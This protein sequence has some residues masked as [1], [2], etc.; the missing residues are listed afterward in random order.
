MSSIEGIAVE[1]V[2]RCPSC[3]GPGG[4]LHADVR[5]HTFGTPG[6]WSISRCAACGLAWLDPRPTVQDIGKV[7]RSYYTHQLNQQGSTLRRHVRSSPITRTLLD[8]A[9]VVSRRVRDAVLASRYGYVER[10]RN[11]IDRLIAS[12][13]G[14]L[15]GVGRGIALQV[16][17]LKAEQRGRLLDVG[18]GNGAFLGNMKGLGWECV[19]VETD[20]EAARFARARFDLLVYEGSLAEGPFAD[21]SFDVITLSHVIEHVHSP[22]DLLTHCRRLLKPEGQLI[23]LTPN[24]NG[25]GHRIFGRAWRGLEPP[26]HLH[27]FDRR[28]LQACVERTGLEVRRVTTESRMMRA[29]WYASRLI[30]RAEQGRGG[31]NALSDYLAAYAM[32]G[33]ESVACRLFKGAGE[34]VMLIATKS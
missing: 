23:V 20:P 26:R 22:L 27:C 5:D 4:L 33:I 12:T 11:A 34:E 14:L 15:P 6:S 1:A 3:Q 8:G 29:I 30:Q 13:L 28:T 17:G 9:T 24:I 7:Y 21:N 25:M 18:C 2:P 19:G 16:L 32:Q 31:A 10:R